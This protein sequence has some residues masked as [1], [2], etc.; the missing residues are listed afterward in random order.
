L[1]IISNSSGQLKEYGYGEISID[2][3]Y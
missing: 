3:V 2:G 1:K